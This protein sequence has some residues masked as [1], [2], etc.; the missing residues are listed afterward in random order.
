MGMSICDKMPPMT[1]SRRTDHHARMKQSMI[2][3][4]R[5]LRAEIERLKAENAVL[6]TENQTLKA[7]LEKLREEYR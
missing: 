1:V 5:R 6:R 7:E 4:L 2:Q 3:N